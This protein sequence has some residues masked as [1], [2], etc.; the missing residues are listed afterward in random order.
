MAQVERAR[1]VVPAAESVL[2]AIS[3]IDGAGKGFFMR[4][5]ERALT[6]SGWRVAAL[7]ADR[8]LH[9]PERRFAPPG[10]SDPGGHFYDHAF[11]FDEMFDQLVLPLRRRRSI[12]LRAA[13]TE[14]TSRRYSCQTYEFADVDIILLEGIFLL[15]RTLRMRYDV[16]LWIDCTFATALER[17]LARGQERLPEPETRQ[18]YETIYFPAQRRHFALDRPRA[19]ATLIVPNDPRLAQR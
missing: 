5:L 2:V 1:R 13:S 7:H 4:R 3:G 12:R 19:A 17:A 11:R 9:L 8:W 18:A 14:E 10:S 6:S 15:K 16:A